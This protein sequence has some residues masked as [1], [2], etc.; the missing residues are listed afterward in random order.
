MLLFTAFI[1]NFYSVAVVI[2]GCGFGYNLRYQHTCYLFVANHNGTW[3]DGETYC[4]AHYGHLL[5]IDDEN[6]QNYLN[7][8]FK[9]NTDKYRTALPFWTS[10]TRAHYNRWY[11]QWTGYTFKYTNWAAGQPDN[12]GG[13][14]Y[15]LDYGPKRGYKWTDND[16]SAHNNYICE[17]SD[18]Q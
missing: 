11:W 12:H 6:E 2:A 13:K 5:V 17:R 18:Y 7:Q 8:Y 14:Q 15:C 16:C 10:G 4:E 3:E 1:I 9:N